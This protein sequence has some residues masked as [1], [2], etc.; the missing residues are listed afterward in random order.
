MRLDRW[1]RVRHLLDSAEIGAGRWRLECVQAAGSLLQLLAP[2]EAH[3][4]YPPATTL[5]E[6]RDRVAKADVKA[7]AATARA[8]MVRLESP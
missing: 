2:D 8:I 4:D 6:L 3:W 7:A 1:R 5:A